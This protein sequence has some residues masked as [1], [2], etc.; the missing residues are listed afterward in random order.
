MITLSLSPHSRA[1]KQ[2]LGNSIHH[3][4]LS[5]QSDTLYPW[6]QSMDYQKYL[7]EGKLSL[8][9]ACADLSL[10]PK[11][12]IW[13]YVYSI[14]IVLDIVRWFKAYGKKYSDYTQT[15]L[16]PWILGSVGVLEPI[17]HGYKGQLYWLFHVCYRWFYPIVWLLLFPWIHSNGWIL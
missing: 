13:W 2:R 12:R 4:F 16:H 7:R 3:S 17:P 15:L 10:F 9:W 6:L 14:Y 8:Y 1:Q 11:Q 5:I